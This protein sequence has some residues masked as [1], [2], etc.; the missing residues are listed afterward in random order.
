[1]GANFEFKTA[2]L[3]MTALHWAAAR[4]DVS[5]VLAVLKKNAQQLMST[6]GYYPVDMA[7]IC[8]QRNVVKVLIHDLTFKLI[9]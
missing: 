6:K 2:K 5:A 7:A 4:G 1:M 3:K 9:Q 8:G